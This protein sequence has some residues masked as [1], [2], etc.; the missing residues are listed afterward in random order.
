MDF[1]KLLDGTRTLA[2]VFEIV[3]RAV[4]RDV[5]YARG[6][7]MLGL[8]DLGNHPQG[9]IG[10]FYPV[11]T[12]VIVMNKVP[13]TRIKETNPDLYKAYAFHVLLHEYLHSV[14]YLDEVQ[15]RSKV[16]A[17][18][19]ELFGDRHPVT[20]IAEDVSKFFPSLVYP[21]L[22]WQPQE[23]NIE[24]VEGFDRGNTGYIA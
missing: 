3:K 13:L 12:N 17:I 16:H 23:L 20:L 10:A 24:L 4:E 11:A 19:L 7:L 2:D 1:P 6:G 9:F 5:G 8:A 22:A 18:S 21:D 15:C 14:G